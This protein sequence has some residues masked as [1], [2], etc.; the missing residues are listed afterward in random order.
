M[1]I[2][3]PDSWTPTD[4]NCDSICIDYNS[5]KLGHSKYQLQAECFHVRFNFNISFCKYSLAA[6]LL[7]LELPIY[8]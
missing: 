8:F 5:D 7:T 1:T 6:R 4:G 2:D 3:D